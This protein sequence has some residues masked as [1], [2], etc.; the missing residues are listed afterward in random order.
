MPVCLMVGQPRWRNECLIDTGIFHRA[1]P[2][3]GSLQVSVQGSGSIFWM[4]ISE[5]KKH[6]FYYTSKMCV[7]SVLWLAV[8]GLAH[9]ISDSFQSHTS[10]AASDGADAQLLA[11]P[12]TAGDP[13][14]RSGS[15]AAQDVPRQSP[16][17]PSTNL[18]PS[19]L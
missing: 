17:F 11:S 4:L 13:G 19:H 8:N 16:P 12:F 5:K 3:P 2:R 9:L 1:T 7:S 15:A 10:S 18:F 14:K 6:Y